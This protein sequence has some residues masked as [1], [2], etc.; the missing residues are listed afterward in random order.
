MFDIDG[1]SLNFHEGYYYNFSLLGRFELLDKEN[2]KKK[3]LPSSLLKETSLLCEKIGSHAIWMGV[4]ILASSSIKKFSSLFFLLSVLHLFILGVHMT[5]LMIY[6]SLK[7]LIFPPIWEKISKKIMKSKD[8]SI[9]ANYGLNQHP[10]FLTNLAIA[11]D[12][13]GEVEQAILWLN[14]ALELCPSHLYIKQLLEEIK[15][16]SNNKLLLDS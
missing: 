7:A 9:L 11:Y 5:T 10:G 4:W 3:K 1:R 14:C 15:S 16:R 8:V 2:F 13:K 6:G 12:K